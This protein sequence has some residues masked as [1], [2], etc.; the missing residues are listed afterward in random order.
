MHVD[1]QVQLLLRSPSCGAEK[2][3][4]GYEGGSRKIRTTPEFDKMWFAGT[5]LPRAVTSRCD[6]CTKPLHP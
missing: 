1:R 5:V 3:P 4:T 2:A 6:A